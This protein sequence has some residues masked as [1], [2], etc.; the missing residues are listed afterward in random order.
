MI[1]QESAGVDAVL[2]EFFAEA[3]ARAQGYGTQYEML[4]RALSESARGGKRFR[5]ALVTG[6]YEVLGGGDH[7]L[8]CTVGAAV[9]LLHTAFVIHDDVIDHDEIRRGRLNV[10]GVF[11]ANAREVGANDDAAT[12]Y[13]QSAAILAGD[14]ALSAAHRMIA[15]CPA[16]PLTREALLDLLDHA[17]F[18]S[19]AGELA[20]VGLS[21]LPDVGPEGVE[22]HEVVTIEARKTAVYSFELPLKAGAVLAGADDELIGWLGRF[23][24]SVGL[25][26]QLQDDLLGVFGNEAST[27]KSA[28][29]DLREGKVTPL[30]A[31][32]FRTK[33]WD[34]IRPHFGDPSICEAD[35]VAVRSALEAS[36]SRAF[37]EAL[38]QQY[39]EA[40]RSVAA[41][42]SLPF[43]F[44]R[45]FDDVSAGLEGRVA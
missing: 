8:A 10:G 30:M 28:M 24:R 43:E 3:T 19:A 17:V 5:P 36:G 18:A 26:F 31:H 29:T 27:G 40:A 35:M 25:A 13:G 42:A 39:F 41:R 1:G 15:L 37:V 2:E 23:G 21:I 38:T 44:T 45:W 9:E 32:A 7:A 6:V 4:W 20:D 16:P 33:Q 22:L 14:L 11:A 12:S 34:R